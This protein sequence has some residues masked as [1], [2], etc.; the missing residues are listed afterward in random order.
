MT[1]S[2]VVRGKGDVSELTRQRVLEAVDRLGY[3]PSSIARSL[4]T[5]K[6]GTLG[7][8]VPDVTNS[9]F[10]EITLSVETAAYSQGY[11]VFLC[12][13]GE[14]PQRELD[15][16]DSLEEKRVDGIIL[17]SSRLD[18][19]ELGEV[20]DR[21]PGVVLINRRWDPAVA[22]SVLVDHES[23]AAQAT[24]HL[25][26]GGHRHI[27]FVAGPATSR[28]SQQREDGYRKALAEA[29]IDCNPD[30]LRHCAPTIDGGYEAAKNLLQHATEITAIFCYN[31]LIAV[32]AL[33]ACAEMGR[34]VPAD[35]AIIGFD[36]IPLAALVTP[37]LTTCRVDRAALGAKAVDLLLRQI[38]GGAANGPEIIEPA[39][40]IRNSAP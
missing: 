21:S 20:V 34:R 24:Q 18:E 32:G 8:V 17:C 31:D 1:V 35:I 5:Q 4:A 7:L 23:G 39:L 15:L 37:P 36:D 30:W 11:N 26:A 22:R 28:G 16:L 12:N 3:R 14:D 6:T 38:K 13:A 33:R 9:F 29:S 25:L 40:V 10:A 27:G 2:R 19:T